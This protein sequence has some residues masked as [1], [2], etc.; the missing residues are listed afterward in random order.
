M[1]VPVQPVGGRNLQNCS[2]IPLTGGATF[3]GGQIL[4]HNRDVMVSCHTDVTGCLYFDFSND[5]HNWNT[6]PVNGFTVEAN[7]HEFHVAVKGPRWFRV[8]L[9]NGST[10]QSFLRLYTYFGDFRQGNSPI[11]QTVGLDSDAIH[12]RPTDVQ[13]EISLGRRT[14]VTAWAKFGWRSLLAAGGDETV[15]NTTGN[16][17]PP[18]VA[19]AM[20]IAYDGTGGGSTDGADTTG[21]RVLRIWYIDSDGLPATLDHTLG[22][23]GSDDTT[24]TTLGINRVQV[25]G[26]GTNEVNAS[27]ITVTAVTGGAKLA[28]VAAGVGITEQCIFHCG[29]NHDTLFKFLYL[30]MNKDSGGSSTVQFKGFVYIRGLGVTIEVFR[31]TLDDTV[32]VSEALNPQVPFVVPATGVLYFTANTSRNGVEAVVRFSGN[33]YQRT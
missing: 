15:W 20:R 17:T 12:V 13:E 16:Y 5:G 18:K 22:T 21:A 9:V 25:I 32:S 29:S 6:F 7:I 8:R 33:E 26:A 30:H 24:E 27:A 3:T 11:N 28:V 19:T 31:T 10:A 14:G 1:V 4:D 2:V 23:D